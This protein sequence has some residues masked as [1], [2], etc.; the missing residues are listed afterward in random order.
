[1]NPMNQSDFSPEAFA[2]DLAERQ[3]MMRESRLM[4]Y[5][6]HSR[7]GIL[8]RFLQRMADAVDPTGQARQ[9]MR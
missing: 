1:M 3:R 4:V 6:A 5:Q 7:A 2:R 8:A 9:G